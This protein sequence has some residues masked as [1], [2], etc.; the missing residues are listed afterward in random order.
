ML[1]AKI[2]HARNCTN[3]N[4]FEKPMMIQKQTASHYVWGN[5]CDGWHLVATDSLSV[6]EER[7]PAGCS[8]VRHY[9][10]KAR[11]FFYVLSGQ[12]S[13]DINGEEIDLIARQGIEIAPSVSHRVFNRSVADAE[14]LVISCP[15][16]HGDRHQDEDEKA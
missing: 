3:E 1:H 9:H 6:I 11:Q 5:Q 7:V 14:F 12:L 13:F 16:S 2:N 15:P 4:L 8:E 10:E